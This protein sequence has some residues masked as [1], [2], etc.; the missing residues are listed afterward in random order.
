MRLEPLVF[1]TREPFVRDLF[2][3]F[4]ITHA[5][6][7]RGN[8]TSAAT[9]FDIFRTFQY[10]SINVYKMCFLDFFQFRTRGLSV[11]KVLTE[12]LYCNEKLCVNLSFLL[13]TNISGLKVIS[14]C[15]TSGPVEL[16][17]YEKC[18]STK[19]EARVKFL[20]YAA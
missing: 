20:R 3:S 15:Y 2:M 5:L 13:P 6:S 17:A 16:Q 8:A 12:H 18:L 19:R 10:A 1:Q 14:N 11:G 9:Y 7:S 4:S